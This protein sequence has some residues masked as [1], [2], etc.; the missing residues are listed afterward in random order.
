MKRAAWA[1][2]C[3][4]VLAYDAYVLLDRFPDVQGNL[5]AA[6]IWATP[7][8]VVSHLLHQRRADRH[9]AETQRRLDRQDEAIGIADR[10]R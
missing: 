7:A 1:L 10:D 3:A 6:T 2:A 5:E 8:L 9:H 4:A